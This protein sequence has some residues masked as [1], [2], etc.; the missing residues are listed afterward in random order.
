MADSPDPT[1]TPRVYTS[2]FFCQT[3]VRDKNDLLTA[4]RITNAFKVAPVNVTVQLAEGLTLTQPVYL[5]LT[6]YAVLSFYSDRPA[7]VE[8]RIKGLDPDGME[9][10][11][12]DMIFHFHIPGGAEGHTLNT[13]LTLPTVK[14][15]DYNFEVYVDDVLATKMPMRIIHD[16]PVETLQPDQAVTHPAAASE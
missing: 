16:T 9:S 5:P 10:G 3:V 7:D 15:G 6:L 11:T 2:G 14:Q 13:R 1:A 8:I 4:V 12:G